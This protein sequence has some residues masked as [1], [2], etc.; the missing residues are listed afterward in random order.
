M[1]RLFRKIDTAIINDMSVVEFT[2]QVVIVD[3][4]RAAEMAVDSLFQEPIVGIDTETRPAFRKGIIHEVALLQ[5]STH[6]VCYL[7]RLNKIG[8]TPAIVQ[9]LSSD[10]P[11]MVGLSLSDD[12]LRLRQ[13]C[14]FT[15]GNFIDLQDEVAR[16]GIQDRGLRKLYANFFQQKI[17]KRQQL[18]NWEAPVL[19]DRQVVYAATDAWA[20]LMLY[21]EFQRLLDSGD[22]Y[23]EPDEEPMLTD[24]RT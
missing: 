10:S 9:L 17:S 14:D 21:E 18:S 16:F 8:L 1:K 11:A 6:D 2:G 13:R 5:V 4:T 20:C 19:S 3:T 7:F 24:E 23:V 15:P 12:L 22:Y